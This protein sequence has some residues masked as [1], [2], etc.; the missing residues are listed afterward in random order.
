MSLSTKIPMNIISSTQ[1]PD[2]SLDA[3]IICAFA[4]ERNKEEKKEGKQLKKKVAASFEL[5][6]ESDLNT[7][8]L[9]DIVKAARREEFTAQLGQTFSVYLFGAASPAVC[10]VL[11]LGLQDKL[12]ED[13]LRK[14]GGFAFSA[15]NQK[16]AQRVGF[17]WPQLNSLKAEAAM[18]AFLEG[19]QLSSYRFNAYQ[20]VQPSKISALELRLFNCPLKETQFSTPIA[21]SRIISNSIFLAR[22]LVNE[23]PAVAFPKSL[24]ERA[25]SEA[26][27]VG[28]ACTVLDEKDLQKERCNL[29]LAVGAA[30]KDT[31]PPRL[32]RLRYK[33][34]GKSRGHIA[35]I[36]KGVTFDTGGL[37]L[38]P[39]AGM[40]DMKMDMAGS[41]TVLGTM[42]AVAQL[43]PG[44][45]VTGY[46][47]L[48]EN[49]IGPLALHPSDVIRS[50]KGL[51]VEI[52]NTD[53]EGRL[54]LADAID[55]AI[56]K[57]K[58]DTLIDIATLTGACI[59]ALGPNTAGLFTP[60]D[61]LAADI[62]K[63]GTAAG[64][65]FWR[66]PL[67]DELETQLKSS[68]ADMRN[69]GDRLGGAITAA[70]FIKKFVAPTVRWV[71]LDI[72]GPAHTEKDQPYRPKG[73]SGFGVKTL[74]EFI[75]QS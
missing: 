2:A 59:V 43:K 40:A 38:K 63:K 42:L 8:P 41:A 67:N 32:V 6:F 37:D 23:C 46:M 75:M 13:G 61:E 35:L 44:I 18:A 14:A 51:T 62:Q 71:H 64:E 20:T 22:D 36:G 7:I 25:K 30:S 56:E 19:W 50:R 5:A 31:A 29:I 9:A 70:L 39:A 60:S 21:R 69:A 1:K 57:D 48:V 27:R 68:I 11:G 49:G 15:A 26:K 24:A 58:P 10:I 16:K 74:T 3:F 12:N 45:T 52:N 47:V 73:G 66:M 28:L 65:D 54:I 4:L 55:Y 17:S 53:A 34:K 72:A 33:P